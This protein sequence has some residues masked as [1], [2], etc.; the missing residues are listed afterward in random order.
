MVNKSPDLK[1]H[2]MRQ[3]HPQSAADNPT[4]LLIEQRTLRLLLAQLM[5]A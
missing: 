4:K 2:Y 1:Q 5:G 3:T